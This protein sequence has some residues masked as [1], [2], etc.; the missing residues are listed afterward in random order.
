VLGTGLA[1]QTRGGDEREQPDRDIDPEHRPPG[2]VEHVATHQQAA[3]DR[4]AGRPEPGHGAVHAVRLRT[5]PVGEGDLDA[6]QDLRDHQARREALHRAR[7]DE[8]ADSGRQGA[9][10]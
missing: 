1:Q 7:G 4:C 6:G 8:R 2:K 9:G 3:D 10:R 5:L